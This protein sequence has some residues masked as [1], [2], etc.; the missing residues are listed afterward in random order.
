MHMQ[1]DKHPVPWNA[2]K[3]DAVKAYPRFHFLKPGR[4]ASEEIH[5]YVNG[6]A[7]SGSSVSV[8]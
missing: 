8:I 5:L 4:R 7:R 2:S 3:F 6:N 1:D